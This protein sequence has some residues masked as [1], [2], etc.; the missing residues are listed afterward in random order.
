MIYCAKFYVDE[1]S[2]FG[3]LD[4]QIRGLPYEVIMALTTMVCAVMPQCEN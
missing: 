2:S 1:S 3:V 4:G